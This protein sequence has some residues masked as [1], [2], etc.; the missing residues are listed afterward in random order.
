MSVDRREKAISASRVLFTLPPASRTLALMLVFSF[1]AGFLFRLFLQSPLSSALVYG[2]SE[3]I[4]LLA[5]PAL[6]AGAIAAASSSSRR[7]FRYYAFVGFAAACLAAIGYFAGIASGQILTAVVAVNAIVVL[8]W[9]VAVFLGL[10]QGLK[11]V[12]ISFLHAFFNI[13]FLWFWQKI[14]VIE[15]SVAIG[16]PVIAFFKII[17][18]SAIL[19]FGLWAVFF[20][21][22][23][24]GKR[25]F[26]VSTI[27]AVAL[28]FAQWTSGKKEFEEVLAEMGE[29]IETSV[30][31]FVFKRKNGKTQGIFV[32]P[33]VHFGPFGNLGGSE[34]PALMSQKISSETRTPTFVFH[35]TVN[36]DLNPVYSSSHAM[37]AKSVLDSISQKKKTDFSSTASFFSARE[38]EAG[39]AGFSF[40]KNALLTLSRAPESTE[41]IELPLGMALKNKAE[42]KWDNAGL[43]D[44]HNS[45]TDGYIFGVG[46]KEYFEFEKAIEKAASLKPKEGFLKA[47]FAEDP[48]EGFALNNGIGKAGLKTAVF[49]I[50]RK[51]YCIILIDGN[52]MLP[53]FRTSV[54][55]SLKDR[56]FE[57]ADVFSTDT[58]S[59]NN[60]NGVH[61]PIGKNTDNGRLIRKIVESAVKAEERLAESGA[62]FFSKR[63]SISVLGGRRQNELI[64]TVNSIIAIARV[65][66]PVVL[67]AS[68]VLVVALLLATG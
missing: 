51:K 3:G 34:F 30:E 24:P 38:G 13:S 57:W 39:V 27:E 16:S 52:N 50:G 61:N 2:G 12:P 54:L 23:A 32:I 63:I 59:V 68:I 47:G 7:P 42:R 14:G 58:H 49:E 44:R 43:V 20:I 8:V 5:L 35:T 6:L 19:L 33:Q 18:S 64:S 65:I 36:H 67:L 31:G 11:S 41:D 48:L 55:L 15:T 28:F 66:A 37:A 26:G 25:N 46:N 9:F 40:G 1:A 21:L 10:N 60:L 45:M 22:N 4:L 56:K 53:E 29:P 17:F 62:A